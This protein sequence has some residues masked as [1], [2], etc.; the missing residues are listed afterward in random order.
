MTK[1]ARN[2]SHTCTIL[3]VYKDHRIARPQN[4]FFF[5]STGSSGG[6]N[7]MLFTNGGIMLFTSDQANMEFTD[8]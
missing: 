7:N 5:T 3:T 6:E 8:V 2:S 4:P 1:M